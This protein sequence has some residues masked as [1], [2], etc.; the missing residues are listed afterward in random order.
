MKKPQNQP[1]RSAA[2]HAHET[3]AFTWIAPE[4][5]QHRKGSKWYVIAGT[6]A[7]IA[8]LWAFVT[9]NWSLGLAVITF[10]AVYQY[11]QA[12]HPPKHVEIVI[13]DLGIHLG[14][15]FFPYSHIQ[16]F[17]IL[18]KPG[19]TTLNIRVAKNFFSDISIQ[20]NGQNP[21][22]VRQYLV[23]QVAEWEGKDERLGDLFLRLLKL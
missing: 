3:T 9:G 11:T 4:Y 1:V 13:S 21:V 15:Q 16:A 18:Y 23:G 17:W 19:L 12:Y 7:A 6:V 8:T 20:L 22:P 5:I 10:S 2:P 14:R